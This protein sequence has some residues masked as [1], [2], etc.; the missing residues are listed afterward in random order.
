MNNSD[1]RDYAEEEYNRRTMREEN[2]SG[3]W[4][5]SRAKW[6]NYDEWDGMSHNTQY[7]DEWEDQ[8][9]L[10]T[11]ATDR[12]QPSKPPKSDIPPQTVT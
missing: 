1:E 7:V 12:E 6:I 9:A 5:D 4:D 3:Y 11:R 8:A 2:E 10:M